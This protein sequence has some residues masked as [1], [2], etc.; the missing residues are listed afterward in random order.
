MIQIGNANSFNQ[1]PVV[2]GKLYAIVE[3]GILKC[4]VHDITLKKDNQNDPITSPFITLN[5]TTPTADHYTINHNT[6]VW[7]P[8]QKR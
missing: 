8:P 2:Q 1:Q 6:R 5:L 3:P 4:Y 7:R